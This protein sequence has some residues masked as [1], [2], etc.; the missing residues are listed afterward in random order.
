MYSRNYFQDDKAPSPPENYSGI[1][2]SD[3]ATVQECSAEDRADSEPTLANADG[4]SESKSVFAN[5]FDKDRGIFNGLFGGGIKSFLGKIGT[6][7]IL[8]IAVAVFLLF[9]KEGDKECA[10]MLLLL[11]AL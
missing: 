6:E 10:I 1:A 9:S 7:E 5:L 8:I 11:L 4:N 3:E 2:L